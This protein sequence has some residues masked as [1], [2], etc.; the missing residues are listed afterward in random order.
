MS[1]NVG[2][3]TTSPQSPLHVV[4]T[5]GNYGQLGTPTE[6]VRGVTGPLTATVAGV[7]GEHSSSGNYGRLGTAESGVIGNAADSVS[8]GV[9]G[10]YLPNGNYGYLGTSTDGVR[11]VNTNGNSGQLGTANRGVFG[12]AGAV[13]S[14]GVEGIF[15]NSENFGYL[16]TATAGV[17]GGSFFGNGVVGSSASAGDSGVYGV[18]SGHGF[19]VAGRTTGGGSAILGDNSSDIGWAGNFNGRVYVSGR[20]GIGTTEPANSLHVKKE[21]STCPV[22]AK[23]EGTIVAENL[24]VNGDGNFD[25]NVNAR[26][27]TIFSDRNAK[28]NFTEIRPREVLEKLA[29][30]PTPLTLPRPKLLH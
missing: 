29:V 30:L 12:E 25:G 9:E 15:S 11:G 4:N 7:R 13:D 3:G 23:F 22:V 14:V 6:G 17:Q 10:N 20:V 2:I 19:G 28:E 21:C 24:Q 1:G 16:G 18:N 5:N 27:F 26:S 8:V